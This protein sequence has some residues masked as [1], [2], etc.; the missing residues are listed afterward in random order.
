MSMSMEWIIQQE[1]DNMLIRSYLQNVHSFSRRIINSIKFD[2]GAI[3][4][5]GKNQTVRYRLAVGDKLTV[6]LPAEKKGN[7]MVPEKIPLSIVYEDRD[8]IVINKL[9]YMAVTPSSFQKSGTV[10]NGLLAYYKQK[11]WPYTVH[12]VTRLDR[13]TSGLLLV[14]KHRYSHSLLANLQQKHKINRQYKA[15]VEG[16]I[17]KNNGTICAPIGRNKNSIIE[18]KV[19]T[20]GKKA[21]TNYEVEKY[22]Q[23]HTLVNI[24]LETGRTHQIRVHF[25]HIGHPLAGDNLYGGSTE[26]I[27]RQA[28][29]CTELSFIHPITNE[30]MHLQSPIQDDMQRMMR[31]RMT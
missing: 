20:A 23:N 28:L 16:N 8:I 11:Q 21:V 4:V 27:T 17:K 13:N 14:A 26:L 10:A 22:F 24:N 1:H 19:T 2:G 15:I 9:P 12:I 18:R 6:Q 5:N 30:E 29:H 31:Q 7:L 25:S 3:L